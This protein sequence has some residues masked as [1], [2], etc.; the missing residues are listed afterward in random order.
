MR[1]PNFMY[2]LL[3]IALLIGMVPVIV[4]GFVSYWI[5]KTDIETKVKE[6]N[7]QILK[8]NQLRVEQIVKNLEFS[9]MQYAGSSLVTEAIKNP[10]TPKDFQKTRDLSR[11]LYNL[12]ATDGIKEIYLINFEQDWIVRNSGVI[13][14]DAFEYEEELQAIDRRHNKKMYW[15]M[16]ENPLSE[17]TVNLIV[18]LPL[19]FNTGAPKGLLVIEMFKS[20]LFS[21]L[22]DEPSGHFMVLDKSGRLI[23]SSRGSDA[24]TTQGMI[25]SLQ[26]GSSFLNVVA[27]GGKWGGSRL[28]SAYNQWVYIAFTSIAEITEQSRQIKT[29]TL[30]TCLIML[31]LVAV[32]AFYGSRTM[33]SPIRRLFQYTE[34]AAMPEAAPGSKRDEFAVIEQRFRTLFETEQLLKQQV[35]EQF[36][37]M[38]EFLVLQLFAERLSPDEWLYK[39]KSFGFPI[40]WKHYAVIALQIDTLQGTKYAENDRNLLM[41]AINNIAE[42]MVQNDNWFQPM[43]LDQSQVTILSSDMS[44]RDA[45]MLYFHEVSER[46]KAKVAEFLGIQVSIGI[47]APYSEITKTKQAY[48]Q[49]LEA[50]QSRFRLGNDIILHYDDTHLNRESENYIYAD[51]KQIKN[52]LIHAFQLADQPKV[53]ELVRK[54][55]SVIVDRKLHFKEYQVLMEQLLSKLYELI[56]EQGESAH[57]VLGTDVLEGDW[58]RLTRT[59]DI[60][61]WL[62][63]QVSA[64]I[65]AFLSER[66]QSKISNVANEM[67]KIVHEHYDRDIT[68]EYCAERLHFHP[69]YLSRVFKKQYG[70]N[71]TDYIAEFRMD[72]AKTMLE[73]SELKV[74]EIA[75][76]LT[77]QNTTSFIRTFRK[78]VGVTPGKY[79]E[80]NRK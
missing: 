52:D 62:D 63:E 60:A 54:Y 10:L 35:K 64:P 40:H 47:S 1:I 41:F 17:D 50:L 14:M 7:L 79:R 19:Y 75:E 28:M 69:V 80:S 11:G 33:Y 48:K 72:K 21:P 15:M 45:A 71:F 36:P 43:L 12:Q 29:I 8:Q 4:V 16:T 68:L 32:A 58:K 65:R 13:S 42:D 57:K 23:I 66:E 6:A 34:T 73:Q 5:A 18:H 77:Y 37:R 38:R 24:F 76:K 44:E 55:L 39:C 49:S 53:E 3:T 61:R 22:I 46:I 56:Q 26:T 67:A 27:D 30:Y 31:V 78:V 25:S 70:V 2:R 51:L 74:S 59:E 20:E 9:A